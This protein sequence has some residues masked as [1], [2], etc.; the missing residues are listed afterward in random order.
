[1]ADGGLEGLADRPRRGHPPKLDSRYLDAVEELLARAVGR[2]EIWMLDQLV[3]WL[4]EPAGLL[5]AVG[6]MRC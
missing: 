3:G 1:M 4:A 6:S 5:S 2:H